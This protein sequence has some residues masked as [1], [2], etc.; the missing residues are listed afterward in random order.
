MHAIRSL[1]KSDPWAGGWDRKGV[2]VILALVSV[3]FGL[4][5]SEPQK[6]AMGLGE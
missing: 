1:Q 4:V 5:Q 6:M 3:V 2:I